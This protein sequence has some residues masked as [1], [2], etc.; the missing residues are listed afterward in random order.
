MKTQIYRSDPAAHKAGKHVGR[1]T[2]LRVTPH[3]RKG[4]DKMR[5]GYG[6][7]L[8]SANGGE[9]WRLE[10]GDKKRTHTLAR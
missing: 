6:N 8:P 9:D 4:H 5:Q 7:A 2:C 1:G 10:T 3:G